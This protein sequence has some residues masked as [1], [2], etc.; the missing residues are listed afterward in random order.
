[1]LVTKYYLHMQAHI[2]SCR[3]KNNLLYSK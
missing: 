1:M 2:T 3:G